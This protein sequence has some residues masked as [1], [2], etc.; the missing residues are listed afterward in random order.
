MVPSYLCNDFMLF[1]G[2]N[3]WNS[4]IREVS[5]LIFLF[6]IMCPRNLTFFYIKYVY[7]VLF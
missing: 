6:S 4:S 3:F 1:G 7:R 2:S 5:S